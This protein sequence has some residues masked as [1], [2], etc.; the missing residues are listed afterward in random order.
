MV[1]LKEKEYQS[2]RTGHFCPIFDQQVTMIRKTFRYEDVVLKIEATIEEYGL[3]PGDRIPSVR[4]VSKELG[5]SINTVFQAYSV[6]EAKGAITSRPKSGYY[7][8]AFAKNALSKPGST[9]PIP[10]PSEV[11]MSSMATAMMKNAKEHGIV[12][13]SILAP[14]NEFLPVSKL[15]KA[16]HASLKELSGDNFQYPLVEGHPRLLKQIARHTFDWNRSIPQ[17]QILVTNGCMEAINLCL[18][19]LTK[20]G[21]IVAIESPTYHGILQSLERRQLK[22][23]EIPVDPDL[24][25]DIDELEMALVKNKVTACIFMPA[26]HHPLGV[27]MAEENKIRLLKVLSEKDIPLIEDDSLGELC[28]TRNRPLPAKAYDQGDNVLYC[29]SFSKS[30]APGFRIGW[31]SAGKYH[32]KLLSLKF[33]SN[34]STTGILQDA[35]GR[36]LESGQYD[37]H[38][39]RM[40]S[41]LQSQVMKYTN[42]I[43][44]YF[45]DQTKIS[46]PMGGL[47]LWVELPKSV[48]GLVLQRKAIKAGIGICPGHIFSTSPSFHHYIRINCCPLWNK[49]I[50]DGIKKLGVF[51]QQMITG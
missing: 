13:L 32:A 17:D 11:E 16:V 27:S 6:L 22:A 48:D 24:G 26:C 23:L 15:N 30:L 49:K 40:R 45:P 20:P 7:I 35:I 38:L 1:T 18:D 46:T 39:F 44:T 51:V 36:Y 28:F 10:L 25:L 8:N 5:I 19:V 33:G 41:A 21:D 29:S 37:T 12:N 50:E 4:T 2:A 9:E 14:V 31:V 34:I 3:K 43:N 42:A 47:S